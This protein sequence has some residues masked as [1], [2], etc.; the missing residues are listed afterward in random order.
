MN[1]STWVQDSE[2]EEPGVSVKS[3]WTWEWGLRRRKGEVT[4]DGRARSQEA[5]IMAGPAVRI[6][7]Q[8]H[9]WGWRKL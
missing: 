9:E 2:V 6:L 1:G 5:K 7:K 8:Q 4:G 3:T